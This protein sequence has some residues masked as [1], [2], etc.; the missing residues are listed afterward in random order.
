MFPAHVQHVK[1]LNKKKK[2]RGGG[3]KKPAEDVS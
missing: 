1:K 2:M 3:K